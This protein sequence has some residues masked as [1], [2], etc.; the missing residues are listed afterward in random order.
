MKPVFD[1][2]TLNQVACKTIDDLVCLPTSAHMTK[3]IFI[4]L[5]L[6]GHPLIMMMHLEVFGEPP[7]TL[8]SSITYAA[9]KKSL[10]NVTAA[11]SGFFSRIGLR[12]VTMI[13][14]EMSPPH[15]SLVPKMC[16]DV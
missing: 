2:A 3:N 10:G 13:H 14:V 15:M 4:L 1:L 16:T 6:S 8:V 12:R 9:F 5:I 11:I 7:L